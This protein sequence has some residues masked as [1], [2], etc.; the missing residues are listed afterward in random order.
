MGCGCVW[1]CCRHRHRRRH[2]SVNKITHASSPGCVFDHRLD[3]ATGAGAGC[4]PVHPVQREAAVAATDVA[5]VDRRLGSSPNR[6]FFPAADV[7]ALR[8]AQIQRRKNRAHQKSDV[9]MDTHTHVHMYKTR[10]FFRH[11][12]SLF[13]LISFRPNKMSHASMYVD[14]CGNRGSLLYVFQ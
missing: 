12:I 13:A 4:A 10:G 3:F 2:V 1:P 7:G 6:T 11:Y 5:E 9:H 14:P 8:R